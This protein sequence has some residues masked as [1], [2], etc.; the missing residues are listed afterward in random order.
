[1][2]TMDGCNVLYLNPDV[3]D[4][5]TLKGIGIM[6]QLVALVIPLMTLFLNHIRYFN[7]N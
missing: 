5:Q 1:M 6:I 2:L 3:E 7:I 4:G